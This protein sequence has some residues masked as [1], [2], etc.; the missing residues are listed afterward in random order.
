MV[1]WEQHKSQHVIGVYHNIYN[2][3]HVLASLCIFA[4]QYKV[5]LRMFK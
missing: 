1:S 4:M 2:H 3:G 5:N